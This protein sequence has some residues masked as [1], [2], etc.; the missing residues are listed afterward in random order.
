MAT[1][2]TQPVV[3]DLGSQQLA[4]LAYSYGKLLDVLGTLITGLKT[5]A[6]VPAVNALA[7][8]AEASLEADA[9]KVTSEP[10]VPMSP[11]FTKV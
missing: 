4:H 5:A 3:G 8:T 6:D 2:K 1:L 11:S 9:Y 7:V 10:N